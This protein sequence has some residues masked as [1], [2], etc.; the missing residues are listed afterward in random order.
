MRDCLKILTAIF[1][2]ANSQGL[3]A[4]PATNGSSTQ[5]ERLLISSPV[6]HWQTYSQ[7]GS[8]GTHKFIESEH[9]FK[10][11]KLSPPSKNFRTGYAFVYKA[12]LYFEDRG[13]DISYKK[14]WLGGYKAVKLSAN[15]DYSALGYNFE[16]DSYSGFI[17]ACPLSDDS[18]C[19]IFSFQPGTY[20][21]VYAKKEGSV[22]SITNYGDALLFKDGKWCRM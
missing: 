12:S 10:I 21:Y 18:E 7:S 6:D 19:K 13:N 16:V 15:S 14:N 1:A 22:L 11:K 8:N 2:I 3:F 5:I 20:P 17:S 4:D 9:G